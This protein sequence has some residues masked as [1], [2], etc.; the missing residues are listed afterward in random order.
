MCVFIWTS[1]VSFWLEHVGL[2]DSWCSFLS[3]DLCLQPLF[4]Q[5]NFVPLLSVSI[6]WE[7]CNTFIVPLIVSWKPNSFLTHCIFF[8]FLWPDNFRW[9]IFEFTL[10]FFCLVKSD[11]NLQ[12]NFSI[13]LYSWASK[14]LFLFYILYLFLDIFI[15]FLT[16]LS[17]LSIF[18]VVILNSSSGNSYI[19]LSLGLVFGD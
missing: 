5:I 13:Q 10:S 2:L 6:F 3:P 19:L 11:L 12:M 15:F 4:L 17:S 8:L 9:S 7:C 18:M 14:Y 1:P 16:L